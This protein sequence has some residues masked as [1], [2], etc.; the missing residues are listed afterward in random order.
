VPRRHKFVFGLA[1]LVLLLVPVLLN[2]WGQLERRFVFFPTREVAAT[3]ADYGVEFEDVYFT[4]SDGHRLNGWYIPGPADTTWLW[5]HG[6]GG[7]L[8]H[9]AEEL[10]RFHHIVEASVFIF[11]YRGY[12]KSEGQPSEQGTYRDAR[13]ALEYVQSRP[14]GDDARLVYFG[15]SLGAAVAV[16]LAAEHPPEGMVLVSP[17]T[18]LRDMSRLAMPQLPIAPWLAGNRYNSLGRI[19]GVNCPALIIHGERDETVPASHG[20]ALYEAAQ[21]PK[22]FRL[23]PEAG[24]NDTYL[25]GGAGY[26]DALAEFM[27]S[28]PGAADDGS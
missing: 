2:L 26:W 14:G 7:D 20:Q 6:N 11:D 18:S 19:A 25:A 4:N 12:G 10:A 1:L 3:P 9:R 16:E 22:F 5:F 24:H 21:P 28:L 8:G 23:L 13:A 27:S 15:R 17:F